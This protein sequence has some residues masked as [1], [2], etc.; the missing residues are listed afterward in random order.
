MPRK[1]AK[2]ELNAS[3][4]QALNVMINTKRLLESAKTILMAASIMSRD[5]LSKRQR[6]YI[7]SEIKKDGEFKI[8]IKKDIELIE[9][10]AKNT[11]RNL[12]DREIGK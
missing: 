1:S 7:K 2:K 5:G 11:Q 9:A 4:M 3:E 10:C 8:N 12:M 6:E